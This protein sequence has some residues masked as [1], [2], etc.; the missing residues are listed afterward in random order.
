M[1]RTFFRNLNAI[2]AVG[3]RRK[4]FLDINAEMDSYDALKLYFIDQ[5]GAYIDLT[6]KEC[7]LIEPSISPG[8]GGMSFDL[9]TYLRKSRAADKARK[10]SYSCLLL[11]CKGMRIYYDLITNKDNIQTTFKPFFV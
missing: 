3:S 7:A 2:K 1:L 6:K 11:G 5:Q 8:T 10:D 4:N 9:P